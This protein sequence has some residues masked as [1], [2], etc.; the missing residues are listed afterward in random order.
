MIVSDTDFLSAF[1]KIDR[2]DF[3]VV[4]SDFSLMSFQLMRKFI[5]KHQLLTFKAR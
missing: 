5:E 2:I 4:L 1:G 3:L